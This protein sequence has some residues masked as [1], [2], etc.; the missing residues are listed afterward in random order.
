MSDNFPVQLA[1]NLPKWSVGSLLQCSAAQKSMCHVIPRA[2]HTRLVADM[3]PTHQ[4]IM[5]CQ[6]DLK[7]VT[8]S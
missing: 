4:T 5:T 6:D 3:L 1:M 8:S 7:S 2:Q